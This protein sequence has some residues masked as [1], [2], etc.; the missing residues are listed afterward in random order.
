M[1]DLCKCK[2][3]SWKLICTKCEK[4]LPACLD[5]KFYE[6]EIRKLRTEIVRLT[7]GKD[8]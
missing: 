2:D 4:E 8:A 3:K 6:A 5:C 1:I 7:A